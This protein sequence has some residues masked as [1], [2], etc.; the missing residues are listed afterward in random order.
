MKKKMSRRAISL[1]LSTLLVLLVP[2]SVLA[3]SGADAIAYADKWALGRN[4]A[5]READSD[6]TNFVSQCLK[7]GGFPETDGWYY[8]WY[9]DYS[10][11]WFG[12]DSLKNYLKYTY[13]ATQL[14]SKWTVNGALGSY[15]Y[16]NDSSNLVGNGK[17]VIFYDWDGNGVMNHA[18]FCVGTGY[19]SE[20]AIPSRL[21]FGDLVDAHTSD[22]YRTL[23]HLE[24]YNTNVNTSEL[25][26]F[27]V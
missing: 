8:N 13:G 21:Y 2:C 27:S 3:Y 20:E 16:V 1:L 9:Y 15:A 26:A 24:K 12:A 19:D 7:A 23:W 17:E 25:Y 14:V 10:D 18:A 4:P 22:H 5:Y 6:C 11:S